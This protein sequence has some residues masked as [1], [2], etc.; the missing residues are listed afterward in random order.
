MEIIS[1]FWSKYVYSEVELDDGA[2]RL[3]DFAAIYYNTTKDVGGGNNGCDGP[4]GKTCMT[5]LKKEL[6]SKI[7]STIKKLDNQGLLPAAYLEKALNTAKASSECPDN[8]L[9]NWR[10]TIGYLETNRT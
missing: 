2:D 3:T 9:L 4:F 6:K 5:E 7:P 8:L 1:H 10:P